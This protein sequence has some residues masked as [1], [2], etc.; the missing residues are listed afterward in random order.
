MQQVLRA[1]GPGIMWAATGIGVS[2]IV[3]AT[4][5]GSDFGL[6]LAG[7]IVLA[8][9]VKYPFFRIGPWYSSVTGKS[10]LSGYRAIGTWALLLFLCL[11]FVTMFF[12]QA[13]V[14]IVTSALA[15]NLLPGVMSV[16]QWAALILA[17]IASVLIIGRTG[18][19]SDLL[20]A[21][22]GLLALLCVLA[23]ILTAER[24]GVAPQS[25]S[26]DTLSHTLSIG[27][28]V[29][30]MGWMPTTIEV[31]VWHSFWAKAKHHEPGEKA[32][33]A[34]LLDF[35]LGYGLSL[36]LALLFMWLGAM[37]AGTGA[38]PLGGNSS[39]FASALVGLFANAL[40]GEEGS[41]LW[42]LMAIVAF[43]ALLSTTFAVSDGF[44]KVWQFAALELNVSELLAKRVYAV[45]LLV[46]ALGGFVI[47]HFFA[48]SLTRLIDFVTTVSFVS[49]PIYAA[50]NLMVANGP[51]VAESAR[52][53]R[54]FNLFA[55]M[56]LVLLVVFSGYFIYWRFFNGM[57]WVT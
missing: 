50:L 30:L 1:L 54:A 41:W 51:T 56:M 9:L 37:L 10:L 12:V 11:T 14:T 35:N 3:Q 6:W 21:M 27:F 7:F 29:A 13:G 49:A 22:M 16:S 31:S 43:I 33:K 53:S 18:L 32:T 57:T 4:R 55:L 45:A 17:V 40:G 23:T 48:H 8:H 2:H 46:L 24:L 36:C 34:S 39:Q 25:I 47:I 52:P 44:P 38:A 15:A 28:V 20:K 26:F 5:A 42:W 19:L